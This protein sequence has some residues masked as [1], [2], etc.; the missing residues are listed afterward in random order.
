MI[1]RCDTTVLGDQSGEATSNHRSS[2]TATVASVPLMPWST[3]VTMPARARCASRFPPG[4][5]L[6][7]QRF[8]PVTASYPAKTRSCHESPR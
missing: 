6:V 7:I 2:S 8:L 1:E 3:S 5:V 4:T